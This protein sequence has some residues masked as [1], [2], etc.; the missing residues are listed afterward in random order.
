MPNDSESGAGAPSAR[1]N[2]QLTHIKS[3]SSVTGTQHALEL[4]DHAYHHPRRDIEIRQDWHNLGAVKPIEPTWLELFYDL[5]YVGILIQLCGTMVQLDE[6]EMPSKTI[7]FLFQWALMVNNW[8]DMVQLET[9]F[10]HLD[11]DEIPG[12]RYTWIAGLYVFFTC[13]AGTQISSDIGTTKN[14]FYLTL[15]LSKVFHIINLWDIHKIPR[16]KGYSRAMMAATFIEGLVMLLLSIPMN[17]ISSKDNYAFD[18]NELMRKQFAY[19]NVCMDSNG[20]S[21]KDVPDFANCEHDCKKACADLEGYYYPNAVNYST[22]VGSGHV[23]PW[24]CVILGVIIG[25]LKHHWLHW[26][27][28]LPKLMRVEGTLKL[29]PNLFHVQSRNNEF[30]MLMIGEGVITI[31]TSKMEISLTVDSQKLNAMTMIITVF[32]SFM[33]LLLL[34][35][36]WFATQQEELEELEKV[37]V[38]ALT[39]EDEVKINKCDDNLRALV[40]KINSDVQSHT[41]NMPYMDREEWIQDLEK[42]VDIVKI[43][44]HRTWNHNHVHVTKEYSYRHALREDSPKWQHAWVYIYGHYFLFCSMVL[45]GAATLTRAQRSCLNIWTCV[46]MVLTLKKTARKIFLE[47]MLAKWVGDEWPVAQIIKRCVT[48]T[49]ILTVSMQLE[50]QPI[51]G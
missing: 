2:L 9:R 10:E 12:N 20:S 40:Q 33:S 19:S 25:P 36:L 5:A 4:P 27:P 30:M 50:L 32:C 44:V 48:K 41:P 38:S 8:V 23:L 42:L 28:W 31:L 14:T 35:V 24:I 6:T 7:F 46:G 29:P 49:C 37:N 1:D 16:A 47:W 43:Q 15:C 18:D 11:N 22:A 13:F 51:I 17:G 45:V 3:M 34:G 21:A 26:Q 39:K